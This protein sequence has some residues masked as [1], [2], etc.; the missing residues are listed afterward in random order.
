[1][2][3]TTTKTC[4]R[5]FV[6]NEQEF[7]ARTMQDARYRVALWRKKEKRQRAKEKRNGRISESEMCSRKQ[8]RSSVRHRMKSVN[9]V[10]KR[11]RSQ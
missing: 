10:V 2:Q 7:T 11:W 1:M 6:G 9:S 8:Q 5:R 4:M 3:S